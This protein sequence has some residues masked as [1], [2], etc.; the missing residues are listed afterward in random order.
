MIQTLF[1]LYYSGVILEI[2]ETGKYKTGTF[3]NS[4][5]ANLE[6]SEFSLT[7]KYA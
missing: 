5:I 2:R 7:Q 1:E 4:S 6:L 3:V